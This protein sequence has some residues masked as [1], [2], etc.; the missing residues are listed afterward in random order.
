M[1]VLQSYTMSRR[2]SIRRSAEALCKAMTI[3]RL[4]FVQAPYSIKVTDYGG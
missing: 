2:A 3:I 1:R 4:A